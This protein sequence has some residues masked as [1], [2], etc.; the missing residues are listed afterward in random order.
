M[1][2]LEYFQASLV[3][4][5]ALCSIDSETKPTKQTQQTRKYKYINKNPG[6]EN[7]DLQKQLLFPIF[8]L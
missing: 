6:V 5:Q 8:Q 4:K 2:I 7:L 3:S 1:R